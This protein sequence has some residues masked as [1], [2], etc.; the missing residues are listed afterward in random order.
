MALLLAALLR[1]PAPRGRRR[2]R[3]PEGHGPAEMEETD[4]GAEKLSGAATSAPMAGD[5]GLG[6]LPQRGGQWNLYK[7]AGRDGKDEAGGGLPACINVLDG[8]VYYTNYSD[9]FSLYRVRTDGTGRE[10]LVE[11][12]CDNLYAADS[13]LY[14]DRR[15]ENN[16]SH[17]YRCG[18]D[19]GDL[20]ELLP[21]Y[22][23]SY[24]YNGSLC[25]R[26]PAL[27]AYDIESGAWRRW[28]RVYPQRHRGRHRHL[29]LGG[30]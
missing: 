4:G 24:Y 21:G 13:G 28:W 2:N 8:W 15:D 17:V 11:G 18:L 14:F 1:R 27:A 20:Q 19:G 23:V 16:G 6:L 30:G 26:C 3:T 9:G 22:R 12:Y 29:L 5:G 7:A 10:R 25:L